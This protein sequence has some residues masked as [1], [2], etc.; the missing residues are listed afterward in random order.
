MNATPDPSLHNTPPSPQSAP[1]A[2]FPA[3]AFPESSPAAQPPI[4]PPASRRT[5][6]ATSARRGTFLLISAP[7]PDVTIRPLQKRGPIRPR[8]VP[9]SM[10]PPGQ[11]AIHQSHLHRRKL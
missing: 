8:R 7:R 1:A 9:T 5:P 4:L 2:K 6:A 3:L 11:I 10:L